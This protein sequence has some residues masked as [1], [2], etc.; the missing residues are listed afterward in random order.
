MAAVTIAVAVVTAVIAAV[1]ETAAAVTSDRSYYLS[2][3]CR[4]ELM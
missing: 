4:L 1:A 2:G 3:P